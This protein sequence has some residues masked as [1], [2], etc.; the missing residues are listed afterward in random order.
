MAKCAAAGYPVRAVIMPI[1]PLPGWRGA[2]EQ[3]LCQTLKRVPVDRITLGGICSF[4]AARRLMEAKVGAGNAI[5]AE[6]R[7]NASKSSDG[8][9][10]YSLPRRIDAYG[11]LIHIIRREAPSLGIGLCLE[12]REVFE[13]LRLEERI[14]R[15]NCVL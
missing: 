4:P 2:Y 11:H 13:A 6:L 8:R 12:E 5:C 1:I 7:Q 15:C 9:N 3:L 14:G 10:R